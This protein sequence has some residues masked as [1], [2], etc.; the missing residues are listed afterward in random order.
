MAPPPL[1][2]PCGLERTPRALGPGTLHPLRTLYGVEEM[3][4]LLGRACIAAALKDHPL[5]TPYGVEKM[6]RLL[7]PARQ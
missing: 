7:C 4:R 6:P 5:R 2:C 1:A 3:P